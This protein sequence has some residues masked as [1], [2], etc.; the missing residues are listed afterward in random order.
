MLAGVLL[1]AVYFADLLDSV[2][3]DWF[4]G[5]LVESDWSPNLLAALDWAPEPLVERLSHSTAVLA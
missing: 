5:S 4:A 3:L 2:A 1:V